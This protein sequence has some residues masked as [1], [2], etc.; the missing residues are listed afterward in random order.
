MNRNASALQ[1][2]KIAF[3]NFQA[4]T[5]A[6][7]KRFRIALTANGEREFAFLE[8]MYTDDNSAKYFQSLMKTQYYSILLRN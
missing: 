3:F 1:F 4:I 6:L 8:N 2:L 5:I 7:I